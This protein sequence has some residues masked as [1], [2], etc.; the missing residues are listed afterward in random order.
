MANLMDDLKKSYEKNL[1][2]EIK[3]QILRRENLLET[4]KLLKRVRQELENTINDGG[5][6]SP[7]ADRMVRVMRT[8]ED[9]VNS[10]SKD[11][12]D[13]DEQYKEM[14]E[15]MKVRYPEEVERARVELE[16]E[17]IRDGVISGS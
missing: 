5:A 7:E 16:Q 17:L 13:V 15:L 12:I 3:N 11:I 6:G 1:V 9:M 10:A 2:L 4:R 14:V 8:L